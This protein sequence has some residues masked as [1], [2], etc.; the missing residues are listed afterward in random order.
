[1]S[2]LLPKEGTV[3]NRSVMITIVLLAVALFFSSCDQT[4]TSSEEA[5]APVEVKA[6]GWAVELAKH[7]KYENQIEDQVFKEL[8]LEQPKLFSVVLD[9][10]GE[11]VPLRDIMQGDALLCAAECYAL[12]TQDFDVRVGEVIDAGFYPFLDLPELVKPEMSIIHNGNKRETFTSEGLNEIGTSN[13]LIAVKNQVLGNYYNT[14]YLA[15][16]TGCLNSAIKISDDYITTIPRNPPF[17]RN[18]VTNQPMEESKSVGDYRVVDRTGIL[19]SMI[20]PMIEN[21]KTTKKFI[22]IN[23][24]WDS[25]QLISEAMSMDGTSAAMCC[26]VGANEQPIAAGAVQSTSYLVYCPPHPELGSTC[27]IKWRYSSVLLE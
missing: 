5:K 18:P 8:G 21:S 7:L 17:W 1:M 23:N 3:N 2:Y 12:T 14:C 13:W 19:S 27:E 25:R 24:D 15:H 11:P 20:V 22:C 6:A 4:T 10:V 9:E 26:F 16:C